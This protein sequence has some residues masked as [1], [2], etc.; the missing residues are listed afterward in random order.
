MATP[1]RKL[2][3]AFMSAPQRAF[4]ETAAKLMR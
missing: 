3:M 4:I 1:L 2:A